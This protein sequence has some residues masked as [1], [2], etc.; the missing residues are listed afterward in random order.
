MDTAG[1]HV[2]LNLLC[3]DTKINF[4]KYRQINILSK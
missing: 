2:F 4:A 3:N 1:Y